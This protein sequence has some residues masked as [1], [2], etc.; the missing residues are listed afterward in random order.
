MVHKRTTEVLCGAKKKLTN[1]AVLA[2]EMGWTERQLREDNTGQFIE[3]LVEAKKD[4]EFN[5]KH[6]QRG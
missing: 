1:L 5:R 3:A 6:Q 2:L 4:I